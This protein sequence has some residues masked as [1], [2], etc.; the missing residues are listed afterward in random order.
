MGA[1]NV[2]AELSVVSIDLRFSKDGKPWAK[3]RLVSKERVR[4]ANG[5][6]TDGEP[7][8]IDGFV[9]DKISENVTE[10]LRPGDQVVVTG[11][12]VNKQW[13]N[14]QGEK[15]D[16]WRINITDI[17]TS[18][19]FTTAPTERA[20]SEGAPSKPQ[21]DDGFFS[22]QQQTEEPAPF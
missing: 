22:G 16:G 1:L 17:G 3:I 15:R 9:S 13:T 14:D 4:D 7:T 2:S 18:L 8:F 12:I 20:R 6:W 10:S 11:K 5:A 19:R 21:E